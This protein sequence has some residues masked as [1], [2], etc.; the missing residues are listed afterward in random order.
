MKIRV[1]CRVT[2]MVDVTITAKQ[3]RELDAGTLK[4][5][6]L[7]DESV[8]YQALATDGEF[9]Y[10]EWDRVPSKKRRAS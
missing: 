2:V 8:P 7:I 1:E 4:L 3:A 10:D 6:D 5:E 9:E